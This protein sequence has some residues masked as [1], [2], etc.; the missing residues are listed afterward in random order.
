MDADQQEFYVSPIAEPL[1]SDNLRKKILKQTRKR[2]LLQT[3]F[4]FFSRLSRQIHQERC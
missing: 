1:A 2:R 3:F 4:S